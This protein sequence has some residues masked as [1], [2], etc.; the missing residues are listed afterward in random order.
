MT[1]QATNQFTP[2]QLDELNAHFKKAFEAI[3]D[4]QKSLNNAGVSPTALASA[5][6]ASY[7]SLVAAIACATGNPVE[8]V[9]PTAQSALLDLDVFVESAYNRMLQVEAENEA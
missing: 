3:L 2:E 8:S 9:I 5:M 4:T 1:E 7:V 6:G